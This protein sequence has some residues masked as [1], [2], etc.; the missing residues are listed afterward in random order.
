MADLPA[1]PVPPVPINGDNR[2]FITASIYGTTYHCLIDTGAGRSFISPPVAQLCQQGGAEGKEI[3]VIT[4]VAD[5]REFVLDTEYRFTIKLQNQVHTINATVFPGL[6]V[7]VI[8]GL[9]TMRQLG[10]KLSLAQNELLIPDTNRN[11]NNQ[12]ALHGIS[13]LTISEQNQLRSFLDQELRLFGRLQG[14]S[15]VGEHH[16][17]MKHN[18]PLTA[19]YTSRNPAMQ[20]IINK[21]IDDLLAA[22]QIEPSNSPY[23]AP[24]VLVQKKQ[25]KWRLC[26][27]FRQL[28]EHS[29]R[30]AYPLP[31][32][33]HI[34]DKLR[35]AKYI[36]TLDLRQGYWQIPLAPTSRQYTAFIAPNRGLFQWKVMPFGHH[37]APATFQRTIDSVIGPEVNEFAFVYLDD[38]IIISS[39]FD[40][41][42]THLSQVF[43]KLKTANLKLNPEKCEFACTELKYL[44]HV[45]NQQGIHTDPDKV[46]AIQEFPVPTNLRAVRRFIGV[47]SWYRRFVPDFARIIAPLTRL[48]RKDVKWTWEQPQQETFQV[49]KKRLTE[50]PILCCPD[51][52]VKFVLQT[53]ASDEGLGAVLYQHIDNQECV[54]SYISRT[55]SDPERRYS[56]TE[57][58]CLAVVWGIRK[59]RPY[60]EGYHFTVVTDHQALKWLHALENPSGRL[61]RWAL[62][63]QQHD[64]DIQYRKGAQNVVADALSR[65]PVTALGMVNDNTND[66]W[67]EGLRQKVKERPE[68]LPDYRVE[69][70]KIYRLIP[71]PYNYSSG[72]PAD[73]WKLCVPKTLR[74]QVYQ[75]NHDVVT[76]GHLGIAKTIARITK[77]YYWPGM[78]RDVANYVRRCETCQ[79]YKVS[80]Q[81]TP[82]TMH[83][84]PAS[85]PWEVISAD[86]MGP[87]PRSTHG[88]TT[89]LVINDKYTK[90]SEL[91]PL[92]NATT[93]AL[94][95]ALRT[96]IFSRFGWPRTLI[97]DNGKQFVSN[98]FQKFLQQC[99]IHQRCNA[100]YAPQSN[101]TERANRVIKTMIAQYIENDHRRWDEHLP[102]LM[103]ALNTAI[104]TSTGFSPAYLNFGRDPRPPHR[105]HESN[106]ENNQPSADHLENLRDL[107]RANLTK[108]YNQQSR[109]Y[110]LRRRVWRPVVGEWVYCRTH[111]LSNAANQ[112]TSK[113]APK[114]TGPFQIKKFISP[115]IMQV[116]T[117]NGRIQTIHIQH[118]KPAIEPLIDAACCILSAIPTTMERRP[119]HPAKVFAPTAKPYDVMQDLTVSSSSDAD[120]ELLNI[121]VD[122]QERREVERI[123]LVTTRDTAREK[124][125]QSWARDLNTPK[126]PATE[127]RGV[128]GWQNLKKTISTA[129]QNPGVNV[130]RPLVNKRPIDIPVRRP[131]P[132]PTKAAR[133][134]YAETGPQPVTQRLGSPKVKPDRV[135]DPPTSIRGNKERQT[136][137]A[138]FDGIVPNPHK[139]R[140]RAR[141]AR[142]E[143]VTITRFSGNGGL[144]GHVLTHKKSGTRFV[145]YNT[146]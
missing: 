61:A 130:N 57:K 101:P 79:H 63:L 22:D 55:L 129:S 58:E 66:P 93:P 104:H 69:S 108:A 121:H 65:H 128:V 18:R 120:D 40:E 139:P 26:V 119:T 43:Q 39:T 95:A 35:G 14:T 13:S 59:M 2:I 88:N 42:L 53:D 44:G 96:R 105:I 142:D 136:I 1:A 133:K 8:L 5:G 50:A 46:R 73:S 126:S 89:L 110:N 20:A 36:S 15:K 103:F 80:Q 72:N 60:L 90:W 24:I 54:V 16:I 37:S 11:D 12:N 92:H 84:T 83:C 134:A 111:H 10:L 23:S 94:I 3:R 91:V 116:E 115:V 99:N 17:R 62:E 85:T 127:R 82:G 77:L 68:T 132:V 86:F 32:I 138:V 71:D 21:E 6:A 144:G 45:V 117:T 41:H 118:T 47:A 64:F 145:L 75:E 78:F 7:D 97:T 25:G 112:F 28:N 140:D 30:D 113:L 87:F 81:K 143:A 38:I 67:Y 122:A 27:D 137:P 124:V 146:E 74:P 4:Q 31:R 49:M 56:V 100:P 51:F 9:E 52:S 123:A 106:G 34:L 70:D 109:Q 76:A 141:N 98:Q 125:T 29:I 102:E 19:R 33:N 114:F 131:E 135:D 107:V 48:T